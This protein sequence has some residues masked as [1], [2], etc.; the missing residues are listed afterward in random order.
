MTSDPSPSRG[1]DRIA[2]GLM[3]VCALGAGYAFVTS[4]ARAQAA[5]PD[6]QQAETWRV[7]GYAF[8][9]GLF[10]L[11][12]FWPRR[13]PGLWEL[14]IVNKAALAVA[15]A[16]LIGRQVAAARSSALADLILTLVLVAAYVLSRGY[17]SWR[18]ADQGGDPATR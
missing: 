7:L 2:T 11:L 14:L 9:A 1:R 15:E 17:A 13:Y 12:A 6:V 8:F 4:I 18:T 5:G 10:A 3:L 16:A